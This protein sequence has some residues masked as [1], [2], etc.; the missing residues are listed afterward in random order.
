MGFVPTYQL[1][2]AHFSQLRR[3]PSAAAALSVGQSVE[4]THH[5]CH[6]AKT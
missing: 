1:T 6:V 4:L 3:L 2:L 5:T